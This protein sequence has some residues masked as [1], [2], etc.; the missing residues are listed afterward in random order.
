MWDRHIGE[1][2]IDQPNTKWVSSEPSIWFE[3]PENNAREGFGEIDFNGEII[4]FIVFF[5]YTTRMWVNT[6][7]KAETLIFSGTCEFSEDT[8]IVTVDTEEAADQHPLYYL[9]KSIET[10]TFYKEK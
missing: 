9:D 10:V 6:S 8:L 2:P 4:E 5:D 7:R 1:R 3:V